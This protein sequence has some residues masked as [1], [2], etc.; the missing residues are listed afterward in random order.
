MILSIEI[1]ATFPAVGWPPR[2]LKCYSASPEVGALTQQR[3]AVNLPDGGV[4]FDINNL[5]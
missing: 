2:S 5:K 4:L 3:R 1:L